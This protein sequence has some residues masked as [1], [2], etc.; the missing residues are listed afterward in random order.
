MLLAEKLD[1]KGLRETRKTL[2][3][4]WRSDYCPCTGMVTVFVES[5]LHFFFFTKT[6]SGIMD[7]WNWKVQ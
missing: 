5:L 3:W 4:F 2:V 1:W 6:F 7:A